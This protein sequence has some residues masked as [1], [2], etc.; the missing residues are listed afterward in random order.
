MNPDNCMIEMERVIAEA[1]RNSQRAYIVVPSDYALA[2]VT[3]SEVSPVTL[4]SNE[5]SLT[6]AVAAVTE[7]LKRAKS[8]VALPAFTLSRLGLQKKVRQVI[9]AL[10]C[11]FATT[12][13]EKCIIDESD[14][15]TDLGA[16]PRPYAVHDTSPTKIRFGRFC[17]ALLGPPFTTVTRLSTNVSS[18]TASR[19]SR[20]QEFQSWLLRNVRSQKRQHLC[21]PDIRCVR[22]ESAMTIVDGG[23]VGRID[24]HLI[25]LTDSCHFR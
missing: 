15:T 18:L 9:E 22:A 12:S 11:P 10:G 6:I 7:R 21:T 4:K 13:M 23:P 1:H 5:A 3:P 17:Y 25:R 20:R 16:T 8:V 14:S 24:L 19:C 2:P